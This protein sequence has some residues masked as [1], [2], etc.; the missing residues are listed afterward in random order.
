SKPVKAIREADPKT[1]TELTAQGKEL[2]GETLENIKSLTLF[3]PKL[4]QPSDSEQFGV[5]VAFNKPFDREKFKSGFE[6]LLKDAKVAVHA[7]SDRLAVVLVGLDEEYAKPRPVGAPG[8]LLPAIRDAATGKHAVVA[9]TTLANMPDELRGEDLPAQVKPFQPL[10]KADTITARIDLA[11][12]I[13][14]D[15][16]VKT[17]TPAQA[18]DAEQ[19]LGLLAS[20]INE[21]LDEGIKEFDKDP[22]KK[23]TKDLVAL[24]KAG[25]TAVKG[26]KFTTDGTEARVVVRVPADLPFGGAFVAATAKMREGAANARSANN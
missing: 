1:I 7:P 11:T 4:K 17:Q 18:I 12:E 14:V 25:Q 15:V 21:G 9:G 22:N 6:K 20:L 26:A 8:P 5:V 19:A 13:T 16:R 10:F 23:F 24:F 3:V 2:F